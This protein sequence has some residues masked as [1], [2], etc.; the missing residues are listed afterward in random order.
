[1]TSEKLKSCGKNDDGQVICPACSRV[2]PEECC[3]DASIPEEGIGVCKCLCECPACGEQ[4][5]CKYEKQRPKP[6]KR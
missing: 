3:S 5:C 6:G 1:M 4:C 2:I